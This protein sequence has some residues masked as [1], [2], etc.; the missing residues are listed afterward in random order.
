MLREVVRRSPETSNSSDSLD[1]ST[2]WTL[3]LAIEVSTWTALTSAG[4]NEVSSQPATPS[5]GTLNYIAIS[6]VPLPRTR[7]GD[8]QRP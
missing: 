3:L 5:T 4:A 1:E 6:G 2:L 8:T 7:L